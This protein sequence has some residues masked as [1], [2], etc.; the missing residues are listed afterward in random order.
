MDQ[1]LSD[2]LKEYKE[3]ENA[4]L[5]RIKQEYEIK[6]KAFKD[7][8]KDLEDSEFKHL[9]SEF[10]A[11]KEKMQSDFQSKMSELDAKL[12]THS[13]RLN[14]EDE[15]L[16]TRFKLIEERRKSF[17]AQWHQLNEEE[18]RLDEKRRAVYDKKLGMSDSIE[19]NFNKNGHAKEESDIHKLKYQVEMLKLEKNGIEAKFSE[20][21]KLLDQFYKMN[22]AGKE[23]SFTLNVIFKH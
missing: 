23:Q 1:L 3:K 15:N 5:E 20:A 8:Y 19:S 16:Q 9:E 14:R 12:K 18:K 4:E 22:E 13:E 10:N 11:K 7:K 17:A 2:K 6:V 21:Q